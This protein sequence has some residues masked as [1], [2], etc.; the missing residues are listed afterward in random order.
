MSKLKPIP[1]PLKIRWHLLRLQLLPLFVCGGATLAVI[2]LW[3]DVSGPVGIPGEV[4]V[5][6]GAVSAPDAGFLS[7]V[8]VERFSR[9]E[10]GEIIGWLI[11]N[12]PALAHSSLAV[13]KAEIELTRL[14]WM[15]PVLDQ[16]RNL[17][18][19]ESIKFDL[20]SA[21]AD[22]AIGNI[23]LAQARRELARKEE[24]SARG[25]LSQ[26]DLE[27]AQL[28]AEVL[29]AEIA[30]NEKLAAQLERSLTSLGGEEGESPNVPDALRATL[31]LQSERLKLLEEQLRPVPLRA[32]I[33]GNVGEVFYRKDQ[34]IAAGEQILTII[35]P[36]SDAIIAYLR[37]PLTVVPTV[38]GPVE[39]RSRRRD[40]LS[41]AGEIIAIGPQMQ[42]LSPGLQRPLPFRYDSGLAIKVSLPPELDLLPG[43]IV[44]IVLQ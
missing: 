41:A 29:E 35:T 11:T 5:I 25:I 16:Q 42:E 15:D 1:T 36:G 3:T 18:Q 38:G 17:L 26:D 37:Q 21:R 14:G 10:E 9:L 32:P 19:V 7:G 12:P 40:K 23:Q 22:I 13:L 20:L 27:I 44:D 39:I 30:A 33:A 2:S 31:A 34:Y 8:Q 6:T 28:R 43:E 24:L 4:E